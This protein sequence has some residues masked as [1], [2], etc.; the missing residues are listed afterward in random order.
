MMSITPMNKI[1]D[2]IF[3]G[4]IDAASDYNLLK[5]HG[6]THILTVAVGLQPDKALVS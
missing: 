6:I 4:N 1:Q 3:L 5:R 2:G